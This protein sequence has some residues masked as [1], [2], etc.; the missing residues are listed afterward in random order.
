[1]PLLLCSKLETCARRV[2]AWP[3][4]WEFPQFSYGAE[5]E[6]PRNLF[7]GLFT[8]LLSGSRLFL[9]VLYEMKT[10]L[11]S[12]CSFVPNQALYQ[13]EPQPEVIS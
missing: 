8:C 10:N 4:L 9:T 5:S 11:R 13:A 12:E 2:E 7:T 6:Y 3:E 1:M